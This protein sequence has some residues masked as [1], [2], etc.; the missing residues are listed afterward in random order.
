M[1]CLSLYPQCQ[2]HY[3]AQSRHW[4]SVCLA[5]IWIQALFSHG[6]GLW[7]S[8]S[9]KSS[10]LG[11]WTASNFLA[12][13][14]YKM[15][16]GNFWSRKLLNDIQRPIGLERITQDMLVLYMKV[17]LNASYSLACH[18]SDLGGNFWTEGPVNLMLALISES[19][20]SLFSWP[21]WGNWG[22]MATSK[23]F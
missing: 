3:L 12:A 14:S 5:N 18:G 7:I 15:Y 10:G 9:F 1:S 17:C 20:F 22:S 4:E 2:P 16:N 11:P 23:K 19:F 13:E 8:A 21:S 6:R